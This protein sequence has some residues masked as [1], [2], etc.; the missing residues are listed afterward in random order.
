MWRTLTFADWA[1]PANL[2]IIASFDK[3]EKMT[4]HMVWWCLQPSRPSPAS[5]MGPSDLTISCVLVRARLLRAPHY[6]SSYHAIA[7]IQLSTYLRLKLL[8][9]LHHQTLSLPKLT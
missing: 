3:A 8:T 1:K 7:L 4:K 6:A 2:R 5:S 9:M